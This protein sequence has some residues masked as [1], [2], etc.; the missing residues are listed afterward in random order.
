MSLLKVARILGGS[1]NHD[2]YVDGIGY[3]AL[4]EGM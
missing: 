2:S 1:G 3:L 4:A